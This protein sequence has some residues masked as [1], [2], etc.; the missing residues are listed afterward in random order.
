MGS[1]QWPFGDLAGVIDLAGGQSVHAIAGQ[2]ESY[3]PT[4]AS[5]G[6][7]VALVRQ[8]RRLGI[9]SFYIADLDAI[10]G[11]ALQA[12]LLGEI[13]AEAGGEVLVDL[14]WSGAESETVIDAITTLVASHSCLG[15]IAATETAHSPKAL[16]RLAECVAVERICLGLDFRGGQF[17]VSKKLSDR[18]MKH[19]PRV[20]VDWDHRT[21]LLGAGGNEFNVEVGSTPSQWIDH[22]IK[23]EINRLVILDIASVGKQVGAVTGELCREIKQA[24][25]K[26]CI[27]S[28]GG[29][30]SP[31]DAHQL[32]QQGCSRCLIATALHGLL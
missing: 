3:A 5:D 22:A 12:A 19:Q 2:R 6:D 9:Q 23:L 24:N 25:P 18:R 27:W 4:R 8:Y 16:S 31:S 17:L 26:L 20:A 32:I 11:Q 21:P 1:T 15:I 13:A 30:R 14:G 10:S 7:P 29:I 28:G